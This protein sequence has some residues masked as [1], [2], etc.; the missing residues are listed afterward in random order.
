MPRTVPHLLAI[1]LCTAGCGDDGSPSG[2]RD[3]SVTPGED[4]G[5]AREDGDVPDRDAGRSNDDAGTGEPDAGLPPI[6]DDALLPDW[7]WY[8]KAR[9]AIDSDTLATALTASL[10]AESEVYAARIVEG[11]G[12]ELGYVMYEAGGGAF[13][14]G[15]W[16]ASTVKVLAALGALEYVGT[17][18]FTGAANVTFDTGFGDDLSAIVDRAIRVSSNIDYDRTVRVAGFDRFNETFLSA[19]RG[20]PTTVIQRSYSGVGVRWT[21]G[22]TLTEGA[23]S[24]Y[25]PERTAAGTFDCPDDGNC[26]SLF[27][28]SEAVRRVVLDAEVPDDERFPIDPADVVRVNDALCGATPSFFATGADAALGGG[29]R[30]CHKPGWVPW[31]DCLDHGLVESAAGERFLLA[32]A[33]PETEGRSDCRMLSPVAELALGALS[34]RS[35]GMQ[36]QRDAGVPIRVQLD[37]LGTNPEGMRAYQITVDA[38]GADRVE[39]F[40]DHWPIGEAGGGGPRFVVDYAYLGGGERLMVVRAWSGAT[41]VGYRSLRVMIVPP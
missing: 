5:D 11:A 3:G 6:R 14:Q 25:V 8:E 28:L 2:D 17:M 32:V 30:I 37:D 27:E 7:S 36:L 9:R 29:T 23:M 10:P 20:F 31:N 16:P 19:E 35:D 13:S 22:I 4:A 1:L 12:G 15:F 33:A 41:Q 26:A 18:G 24:A 38:A 34:G 40:T 39:L 21:P